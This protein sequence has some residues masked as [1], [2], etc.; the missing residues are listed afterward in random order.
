MYFPDLLTREALKWLDAHGE[1]KFLL[2]LDYFDPHEPWDPPE[3]YASMYDPGYTGRVIPMPRGPESDYLSPDELNHIRAQY[4][5]CVTQV[6]DQFRKLRSHLEQIGLWEKTIVVLLSDHGE[7][8]GEHG[9]IRKFNIPVYDELSRMVFMIRVPGLSPIRTDALVQNTELP[10]TMYSL[11]G[12][13]ADERMDG[14]DLTP[15]MRCET[16]QVRERAYSGA[17]QVRASIR[18]PEWKFIDNRGGKPNEL[19]HV[20]D[21]PGEKVNLIGR[22]SELA[23]K[24]HEE[25]WEWGLKW[26]KILDWKGELWD[27]KA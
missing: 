4:A 18:T 16:S 3:P 22:E 1:D 17:F 27:G 9:E 11:L 24:L 7:P 20:T 10:P 6:D 13:E 14:L 19:F 21:D 2:W 15:L 8:L 25:L 5:G 26:S 12:I 23:R